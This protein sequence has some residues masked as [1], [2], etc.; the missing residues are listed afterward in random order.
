MSVSTMVACCCDG[1]IKI[2]SIAGN[3]VS[4][5]GGSKHT[6]PVS[7]RARSSI[8]TEGFAWDEE[9]IQG[10][11]GDCSKGLDRVRTNLGVFLSNSGE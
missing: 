8:D 9:V 6:D 5:C 11:H 3:K 2:A 1:A 4:R 7:S 10:F